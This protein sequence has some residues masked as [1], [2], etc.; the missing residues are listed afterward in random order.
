MTQGRPPANARAMHDR[1]VEL[2]V[3]D[4]VRQVLLA[5]A[6]TR[7]VTDLVCWVER[8]GDDLRV[9]AIYMRH[10]KHLV[11]GNPTNKHTDYARFRVG[12]G[13]PFGPIG[14]SPLPDDMI[15]GVRAIPTA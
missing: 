15:A 5:D 6:E 7:D 1:L 3:V 14:S 4:R 8:D 12:A 11:S 13:V 2:G 9:K 10:R